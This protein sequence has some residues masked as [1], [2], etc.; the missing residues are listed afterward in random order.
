MLL[1]G[2]IVLSSKKML[3]NSTKEEAEV[4]LVCPDFLGRELR[5]HEQGHSPWEDIPA[6]ALTVVSKAGVGFLLSLRKLKSLQ[7]T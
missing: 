2:L 1:V 7:D 4:L 3:P 6:D 5:E